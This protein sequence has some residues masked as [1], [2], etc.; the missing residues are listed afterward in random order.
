MQ[1][2]NKRQLA[3]WN[4][5]LRRRFVDIESTSPYST[6]SHTPNEEPTLN[7]YQVTPSRKPIDPTAST[8]Q[9]QAQRAGEQE[10]GD[11]RRGASNWRAPLD[12][13]VKNDAL[14]LTVETANRGK[15]TGRGGGGKSKKEGSSFT[16]KTIVGSKDQP[17]EAATAL[18]SLSSSVEEGRDHL[19]E[20]EGGSEAGGGNFD[21]F[22]TALEGDTY[23]PTTANGNGKGAAAGGSTSRGGKRNGKV[24]VD[25]IWSP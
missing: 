18:S 9:Q 15:E 2:R 23:V 17:D 7:Y 4:V 21:T 14:G 20:T 13:Q 16:M 19:S 22:R 8:S 10:D 1:H 6:R 11:A 5:S 25:K 12:D 24:S 3:D